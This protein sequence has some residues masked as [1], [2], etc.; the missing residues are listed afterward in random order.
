MTLPCRLCWWAA[1]ITRGQERVWCSHA[2]HH[3][4]M[5]DKAGCDTAAFKPDDNRD[6][7][8]NRA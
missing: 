1:D 6:R 2:M 7:A 4:W 3:G 8:T 5:T